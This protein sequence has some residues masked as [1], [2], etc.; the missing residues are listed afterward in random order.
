MVYCKLDFNVIFGGNLKINF[1]IWVLFFALP[2]EILYS[3]TKFD[4]KPQNIKR[5]GHASE[6][7]WYYYVSNKAYTCI[8]G[9][10]LGRNTPS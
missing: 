5:G 10:S 8:Q 3:Q 1:Q 6:E 2:C 4:L 7:A 9:L